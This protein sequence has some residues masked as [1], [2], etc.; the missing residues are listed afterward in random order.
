VKLRKWTCSGNFLSSCR[1]IVSRWVAV[2]TVAQ[3]AGGNGR[4]ADCLSVNQP[5]LS[6]SVNIGLV[7]VIAITHHIPHIFTIISSP[8]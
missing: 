3:T 5:H 6:M 4:G 1:Y 2:L 7:R 8:D